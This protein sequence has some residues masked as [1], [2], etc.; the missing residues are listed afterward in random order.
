MLKEITI[1]NFKSINSELTFSMEADVKR[2]S[3]LPNHILTVNG[4][5]LLKITST[6]GP[7]G[8]GKTN[9]LSAI[10]TAKG[11]FLNDENSIL[12]PQE[13]SCVFNDNKII[14]E[15]IFFVNSKYEIGYQ[16][17]IIPVL[18]ERKSFNGL[19]ANNY[20]VKY[21]ILEESVIYRKENDTEFISLFDRNKDGKVDSDQLKTLGILENL[22]LSKNKSVVN[23]IYDTFA[24][25][26]STTQECLD[27]IKS[28]A[29]E[30]LSINDLSFNNITIDNRILDLINFHKKKL[31]NLLSDVDINIKDIKI[32]KSGNY[33]PIFF[34]REI[35]CNNKCLEKEISLSQES[36][37]TQKIFWIFVNV[38]LSMQINNIFLCD[39]MNSLLHPK[40]SKA[41]INLFTSEENVTSQLIFNSHDII[42]MTNKNFRRDEIWF[43]YR[44]ENYSTKAVP[45]SNIVNYKGEQIRNDAKYY[46]QYLEGRYG[47]DPFIK[48]GLS[49]K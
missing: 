20:F 11:V 6:Y 27:V 49:W 7:N 44:D 41:I 19:A 9:L 28:L 38:L 4:N 21:E 37:G 34:T 1:S 46:K 12:L 35:N 2:V 8:G 30:L 31:I 48:E 17:Q 25:V 14:E 45:L 15:T 16:F 23:Y 26:D 22:N 3:E 29:L 42:N 36:A 24:N 18:E 33:Y 32:Y 43:I 13:I 40:L 39:D 10:A 47:A 5:S